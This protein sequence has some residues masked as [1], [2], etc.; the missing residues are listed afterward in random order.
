[1]GFP[2]SS[3]VKNLPANAGDTSSIPGVGRSPEEEMQPTPVFL[4][5]E[6]HAQRSW[7]ATVHG[8]AKSQTWLRELVKHLSYA[9]HC[10]FSCKPHNLTLIGWGQSII[11]IL[12]MGKTRLE[13][14]QQ[15][16]ENQIEA[17]ICLTDLPLPST[18]MLSRL[19]LWEVQLTHSGMEWLR[20]EFQRWG[21]G[22][23]RG[24]KSLLVPLKII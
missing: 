6:S 17:K 20:S 21:G 18:T 1:M 16:V 11:S 13:E 19:W 8:V 15:F 14:V 5:G 10:M 24:K 4:P 9:R 2:G 23:G 3:V 7:Q 12:Q 22:G